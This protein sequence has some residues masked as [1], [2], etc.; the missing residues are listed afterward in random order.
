MNL[1]RTLCLALTLTT[2]CCA[3]LTSCG[4]G[5]KDNSSKTENTAASVAVDV[6]SVAD[7]LESDIEY[8][9]TLNELSS[10]MIQKL[11]GLSADADYVKGKVF[12][13]SGGA[14]AEEIACFEAKDSDSAAKIKTAL[15]NR[16]DSQK[17]AFENY[18]PQEMTKLNSPVI[19]V[20]DKYVM[21]CI[22]DDN[23]KA[24]EIIG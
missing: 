18:Q 19:V 1:K 2:I 10:D 12:V 3:G 20:K 16:I 7:K 11:F 4:N 6:I 9:D 24:E 5:D 8:K 13:G 23:S 14:T 21:M 17:K 22:S 15:E